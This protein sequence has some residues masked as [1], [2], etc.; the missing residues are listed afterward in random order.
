M[1][2]PCK[3]MPY[4][5]WQFRPFLPVLVS[6][7]PR[8]STFGNSE[9][10]GHLLPTI[11]LGIFVYCLARFGHFWIIW[12][13]LAVWV[14][15]FGLHS[16]PKD[17]SFSHFPSSFRCAWCGVW[18]GIIPNQPG[19]GVAFFQP[20]QTPFELDPREGGGGCLATPCLGPARTPRPLRRFMPSTSMPCSPFSTSTKAASATMT[21]LCTSWMPTIHTDTCFAC[22]LGVSSFVTAVCCCTVS[23]GKVSLRGIKKLNW[24]FFFAK[25]ELY[26]ASFLCLTRGPFINKE[27][28]PSN[29]SHI[30]SPRSCIF[31]GVLRFSDSK[32]G[33]KRQHFKPLQPST[34]S[35]VEGDH[36]VP[37]VSNPQTNFFIS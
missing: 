21:A 32:S 4:F 24:E 23:L 19:I 29:L 26:F 2:Q 17:N 25:A 30:W 3:S 18:C 9:D 28:L 12:P 34:R 13:Y 6:F 27:D 37:V 20:P 36:S 14:I 15:Y 16:E 35:G 10:F 11:F 22:F 33:Q 1:T 8:L 5:F 31:D 7:L